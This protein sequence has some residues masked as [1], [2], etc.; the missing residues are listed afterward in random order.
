MGRVVDWALFQQQNK[1][2]GGVMMAA[3]QQQQ[4]RQRER[5]L[6]PQAH[7]IRAAASKPHVGRVSSRAESPIL[8]QRWRQ[9]RAH[10]L[11]LPARTIRAAASK[12]RVGRVLSRVEF[13]VLRQLDMEAGGAMTAA[14]RQQQRA[15]HPLLLAHTN[16]GAISR[17]PAERAVS[18]AWLKLQEH[19]KAVGVMT[20][21]GRQQLHAHRRLPPA[22]M[23]RAT[24]SRVRVVRV[25]SKATL[26][27]EQQQQERMVVVGVTM[28]V[29]RQLLLQP[30]ERRL[31]QPA[32]TGRDFRR[33]SRS[34]A[35]QLERVRRRASLGGWSKGLD[36][37]L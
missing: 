25:V 12:V 36:R 28:A 13:P 32:H 27:L 30:R 22:R 15:H 17:V 9:L 18:R 5:R 6:L 3:G 33:S 1:E 37:R 29:A 26:L 21:V 34:R 7:T 2:V 23:H 4:R 8:W 24:V 19:T 14:G 20:T 16:K 10:L 31:L 11:L 35:E